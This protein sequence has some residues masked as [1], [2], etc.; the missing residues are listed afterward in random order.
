M[1]SKM[2]TE[3]RTQDDYDTFVDDDT[4]IDSV[5]KVKQMCN[6]KALRIIR[7]ALPT[8]TFCL[9]SSYQTVKE[10]WV[11]LKE[12]YFGEVDLNSFE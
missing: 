3:V 6:L 1:Y 12:L 5:E 10:I 2:K 4:K 8:D 11:R 9:V 7:F